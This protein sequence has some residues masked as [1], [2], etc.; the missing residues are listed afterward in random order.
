MK[1]CMGN[2]EEEPLNKF[3]DFVMDEVTK[4]MVS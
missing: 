2:S 4:A 3:T 1:D